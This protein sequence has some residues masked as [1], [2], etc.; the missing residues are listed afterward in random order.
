MANTCIVCGQAA[1]SGE[2]VFPAALGG[3]RINKNI[4]CTTHDNGYSSLVAALSNQVDVFNSLLGVIPDHSDD[5]KSVVTKDAHTGQELK[6][7]AKKNKFIAHRVI[8]EQTETNSMSREMAFPDRESMNQWLTEQKTKGLDV[9]IEQ[10]PKERT[11]FLDK[12]HFHREIGGPFGLG[13]VAYVAQTFL[14]QAFADLT[15]SRDVAPFIAYTQAIAKV[16]QISSSLGGNVGG[17]SNPEL[18]LAQRKFEA[19][20]TAWDGQPPIWWDFD[21]QPDTTPNAFEFGHRV[22]VGVDAADGQIFGRFSLFSAIHF[23]MCFGTA[24]SPA[25]TKTVTIDINPMAAHPPNDIK[26]TETASALARVTRPAVSTAGLEAAVS[27]KTQEGVF[28]DLLRRIEERSL[29][30]LAKEMHAE[31]AAYSSM[32]PIEGDELLRLV[33]DRRSQRVLNLTKWVLEGFKSQLSAATL[34]RLGPMID[35]MVAHDP[36]S[37]NGLSA[38]ANATLELAKSALLAQMREDIIGG[39]LDERR[40]IALMGE[41]VGAAVIGELVLRPIVS[42]LSH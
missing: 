24:S 5:V 42:A 15:R 4:Y 31:L 13:A 7:S 27:N 30:Q 19:T 38:M 32:S 3:R 10:K 14:A 34:L 39:R 22:T 25:M 36:S 1:G 18:E 6:F 11:Y 20:L 35:S 17:K 40:I 2:H 16:S 41:G 12:V 33:V 8:S 37:P 26:K 29:A 21:P 28:S 23:G 9:I